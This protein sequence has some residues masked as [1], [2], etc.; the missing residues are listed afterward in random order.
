[1]NVEVQTKNVLISNPFSRFFI[2]II[3]A[4]FAVIVFYLLGPDIYMP[5]V[6]VLLAFY[7]ALGVGW[8]VAPALAIASGMNP[9]GVVIFLVFISSESSLIV[10]ANYPLLEKIPIIGRY[11]KKLRRKA[12]KTIEER[13]LVKNVGYVS[14]FWLMFLPLYGT[15]P[16][17][18]TLVGR[19]LGLEWKR[20]WSVVTFSATVRFTIITT[21][22][23]FG[24]LNI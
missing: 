10:S 13:E 3:P 18:M 21:L 5:A 7:F 16:N 2:S 11:M 6:S 23:Y 14:I 17:V 20:V 9:I 24:Y 4:I 19:L 12:S 1:M 15:G 22:L 8:V